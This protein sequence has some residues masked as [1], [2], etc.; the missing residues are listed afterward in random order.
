MILSGNENLISVKGLNSITNVQKLCY[1]PNLDLV[2]MH[3][4]NFVEF[5]QCVLNILSG[6][7]IMMDVMTDNPNPVYM[8]TMKNFQ[9]VQEKYGA[10]LELKTFNC[11]LDPTWLNYGFCKSSH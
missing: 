7:Q 4:Q 11:D 9:R 10:D 5:Y 3:I 2:S 1:N 8:A 6:N